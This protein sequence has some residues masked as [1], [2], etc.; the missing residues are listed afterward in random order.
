MATCSTQAF[1]PD[2]LTRQVQTC[3]SEQGAIQLAD[4]GGAEKHMEINEIRTLIVNSQTVDHFGRNVEE[5][6]E[7]QKVGEVQSFDEQNLHEHDLMQP[8]QAPNQNMTLQNF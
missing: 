1:T 8:T 3:A 6:G 7:L 4:V 2:S 5:V